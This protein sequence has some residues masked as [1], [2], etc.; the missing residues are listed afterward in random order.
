M[1]KQTSTNLEN[2]SWLNKECDMA[3]TL[4]LIGSRWKPSILA[5]LLD[6]EKLRFSELKRRLMGISE[7]T[8][9]YKLK[10]LKKDGLLNRIQYPEVPPK[11]EYELTLKGKTLEPIILAMSA[12]GNQNRVKDGK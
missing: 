5:H 7:K 4:S 9:I 6:D 11:V 2:E 1:R 8:L 10:E 12:W 3:Y